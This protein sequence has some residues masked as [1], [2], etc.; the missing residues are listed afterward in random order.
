MLKQ[1]DVFCARK[2]SGKRASKRNK[3]AKTVRAIVGSLAL[4]LQGCIGPLP[5]AR[6]LAT[7]ADCIAQQR[8]VTPRLRITRFRSGNLPSDN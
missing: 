2:M 5:L 8:Q 1:Y 4:A 7:L 3:I 6:K